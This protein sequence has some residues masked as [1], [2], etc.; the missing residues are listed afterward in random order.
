MNYRFAG[1]ISRNPWWVLACLMTITAWLGFEVSRGLSLRVL[2]E[3]ML[4]TERHNVQLV[5]KF[6]AQ[7]GG[8]N[9]TLIAIRNTK[10][11][12]YDPEFLQLYSDIVD[13]IYYHPDAIRHLV[14]ALS[15]RKTKS[16]SGGGGRVE[17]NAVM[18][19]AIP[20]TSEE[21]ERLRRDVKEQY[22]GLL[23]SD[24]EDAAMIVADFK[25][26][27][28]YEALTI[29]IDK[30]RA[31]HVDAGIEIHASGRPLLLGLIYQALDDVVLIF[32][33]SLAAIITLLYLYFRALIGVVVPV[34]T[35][36]IATIWGLGAMGVVK[37]NLDPLLVLLPAFVF[38][39]V[40]SHSVQFVS[41]VF[42]QLDEHP[43][44][45]SSVKQALAKLL[46]PSGAAIITDAAGFTVLVLVG[47][48]SIQ[49]L[50]LICTFWLFAIFPAL[51]L[52]AALVCVMPKPGAFRLGLHFVE[53]FWHALNL[54]KHSAVVV[55]L[56]LCAFVMGIYGAGK[57]T[58]GDEVGSSI[59]WPES[60]FNK[61]A[62]YLN[63][64]FTLL[65][66]D[67]L[68]VY[69]EGEEN[70][71]VTPSVYHAVEALDR[72]IFQ[73]VPEAK[74]AQSLV[75]VV[76]TINKVLY[77]G[78]P[79]YAVV[80]DTLQELA[81]NTYLFRSKGEP[82]DFAAYTDSEWRIGNLSIPMSNHAADTVERAINSL[83]NF[84]D[85]GGAK[86]LENASFL[87]AGGQ[88]GITKAVNDE[89]REANTALLTA[90]ILVIAICVFLY[91]RSLLVSLLLVFSLLTSNFVTYA[92]MAFNGIGLNLNT[93]VLSALGIGLGVDYGIYMFDRIREESKAGYEPFDAVARS[94]STA[95][96]A[97]FVTAFA[98][99]IPM[100]PWL[101]LSSLRFQAEMGLLLGMVLFLNMI[102]ALVFLPSAV[103][104]FKPKALVGS[105]LVEPKLAEPRV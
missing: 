4:P 51:M 33:L 1:F 83:N 28:D 14:Q 38:A 72:Y 66:T 11:D 3:E 85:S 55:S 95:G 80:P 88:I 39:I 47:I 41:R 92:F 22:Q 30:I 99:I 23:V 86:N 64:A 94:I 18:W 71:M 67:L 84:M 5:Q 91:Y 31:T 53:R 97:I 32:C 52:A 57:L 6:G 25:E 89:I 19:P 78:D 93:L 59:L 63:G 70:T 75:P 24:T 61:D 98:M 56:T 13:E 74:P 35:A 7:F 16:V 20:Q 54:K 102:G 76:K 96:N 90:I 15:L 48:P 58:I 50:A 44:T 2:L 77:E 34:V 81:F 9:T 26:G 27:T 45:R 60:R 21:L 36:S 62:E 101:F 105:K 103:L 65:G 43:D 12:I 69:I 29:F 68:Q 49:A 17:I 42:E 40:L 10:G 46:L 37:Y 104:I 100:L 8:A 79:S 73:H 87:F 82:G